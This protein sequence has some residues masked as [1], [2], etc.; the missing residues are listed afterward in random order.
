M[1]AAHHIVPKSCREALEKIMG[2]VYPLL[3]IQSPVFIS[4]CSCHKSSQR[5]SLIILDV[6]GLT[7][8][9]QQG[10]I[11][12]SKGTCIPWLVAPSS[13]FKTSSVSSSNLSLTLTSASLSL[14]LDID[15]PAFLL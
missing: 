10:C 6:R 3:G 1:A 2:N 7:S 14:L 11:S 12:A 4:Y 5:C 8:K 15:P 13:V 9:Y